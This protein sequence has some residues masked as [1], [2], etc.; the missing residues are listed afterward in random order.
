FYEQAQF[1]KAYPAAVRDGAASEGAVALVLG[2]GLPAT[3]AMIE[4][5]SDAGR[6]AAMLLGANTAGGL[7]GSL[8]TGFALV[9]TL[10]TEA[11]LLALA[12]VNAVVAA[13]ALRHSAPRDES[14]RG[15]AS[16]VLSLVGPLAVLT[17][18]V[19]FRPSIQLRFLLGAPHDVVNAMIQGPG[20]TWDQRTVFLREGRNTTVSVTA[21]PGVLSLFNDGRPESGFSGGRPGFGPELVVLGGLPGIL[22]GE[23]RDAMIIGLGAGHTAA[24][25]LASGFEHVRIVELE[26]GVVEASRLL[27]DG[28]QQPFPLDDPRAE[29]VVD[30][31]RNQLQMMGPESLDAVISQPSHPW[32]AGSSALY[33]V[34]F[35]REVDRALRDDGVFG[36]WVNLF[37]MDM[38]HLRAILRTLTEVFPH[39]RAFVVE[40]SSLVLMASSTPRP[41]TDALTPR[42][43][44]TD[45]AGPFFAPHALGDARAVLA[46]QEM[47][48]EAVAALANGGSI[49][50]DDRPLLELEL[51]RIPNG[52][53]LHWPDLDWALREQPW[54]VDE[55]DVPTVLMRIETV[56]ARARALDRISVLEIAREPIVRGRLA[57]ARGDI[58]AALAAY[59]EDGGL[60]ARRRAATLRHEEGL[61][62]QLASMAHDWPAD[63]EVDDVV[64]LAALNLDE[65]LD[66]ATVE[67]ARRSGTPLGA[68][69][70]R[71]AQEG[72]GTTP[73]DEPLADEHAEVARFEAR[74]ATA[75]RDVERMLRFEQLAWRAR[76]VQA[77][78]GTR[79]GEEAL[80]TGNGGLALM[81]FSRVLRTYPT[82]TRAAIG[83]ARLHVRDGRREE[84]R[85][86]L[87]DALQATAH[88]DEAQGRI[89]DAASSLNIELE[90]TTVSPGESSA[91]TAPEI[92]SPP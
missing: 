31:A 15:L 68:Y 83:L 57:E 65:A 66:P 80:A 4:K 58:G 23:R 17:L 19:M 20:P 59:D 36:L 8:L 41:L 6:G 39:V 64:L 2:T 75:R 85:Q 29:L 22:A 28:R 13:I 78:N 40:N 82:T 70:V 69:F 52:A 53:G 45:E 14:G 55:N 49:I 90:P 63:V 42:I 30:D 81:L 25:A 34:E 48:S 87:R 5:R 18:V 32:L 56:E 74:C 61:D 47:D 44:A 84:A 24:M 1:E 26:D 10:G 11:T 88:L 3:W 91:S 67:L 73:R 62:G 89:V 54:Q 92:A 38:P 50:V 33:T 21:R 43:V 9:P 72:C 71:V 7:V 12:S 46:H 27:Y 79:R 76:T 60:E 77:A 51:A 37:R 35:F 86:V 16:R